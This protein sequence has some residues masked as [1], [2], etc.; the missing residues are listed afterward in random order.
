MDVPKNKTETGQEHSTS[1]T[2]IVTIFA[3]VLLSM[4]GGLVLFFILGNLPFGI[5]VA[6]AIMYTWA[7]SGFTFLH[8]RFGPGYN[9]N[10]PAVRNTLPR[11]LLL[12][13]AFLIVIFV[14]QTTMFALKP[15]LPPSWLKETGPKHESIYGWLLIM[16][17][18]C[19][20]ATEIA[21][22]QRILRQRVVAQ[23]VQ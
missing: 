6:T 20:S 8:S 14:F 9:L 1:V 12:H 19:V 16:T 13:V 3:F 2:D 21:W 18:A 23:D 22:F 10:D 5:Q 11:L 15:D 17:F 7:V 4:F